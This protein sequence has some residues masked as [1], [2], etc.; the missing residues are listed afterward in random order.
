MYSY[1]NELFI[2]CDKMEFNDRLLAVMFGDDMTLDSR[3]RSIWSWR[4]FDGL[5]YSI[6]IKVL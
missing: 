2:T 1:Q 5:S 4:Y 6:K 3:K